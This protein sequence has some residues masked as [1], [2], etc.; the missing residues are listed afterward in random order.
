M[1]K[2][3]S[4]AYLRK[5]PPFS[6]HFMSYLLPPVTPVL[7]TTLKTSSPC[8]LHPFLAQ[9]PLGTEPI[10]CKSCLLLRFHPWWELYLS[11]PVPSLCFL[12]L[13]HLIQSQE[14]IFNGSCVLHLTKIYWELSSWDAN[15]SY[16][17]DFITQRIIS[18]HPSTNPQ[19][20]VPLRLDRIS[21][22]Y[23]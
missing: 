1:S 2:Y 8:I 22:M 15:I 3:S 9:N 14:C 19:L 6:L 18:Q 10:G 7:D 17:F 16:H 12:Y 23:C 21:R 4:P 13:Q 20:P 5:F 11:T